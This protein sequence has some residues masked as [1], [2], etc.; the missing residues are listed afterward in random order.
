MTIVEAKG[1]VK[2][3]REGRTDVHALRGVDLQIGEGEF[4]AVAGPSGSGKTTLLNIVSG[5]DSAT[6]GEVRVDGEEISG[7][8]RADLSRLRL[9]KIGFVF[10]SYNLIPVLTARENVEFTMLLQG[11]P[12]G[13]R[14][15]RAMELLGRVGLQGLEN[16]R[17][18]TLSGGQQQRV[19]VARAIVTRPRLVL[20]D[21]PTANLDSETGA[22]LLDLMRELNRAENMTFVFSTHDPM[23]MDYSRRLIR[24]HDGLVASDERRPASA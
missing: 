10:Q 18:P 22:K 16:R 19:A 7:M 4:I 11:V 21:E 12:A 8:R 2:D 17:P 1:L 3:Y 9:H 6:A 5:L 13:E 14:R 20:A 23:V 15:R 24:L